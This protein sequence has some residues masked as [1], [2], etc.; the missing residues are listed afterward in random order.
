MS[1]KDSFTKRRLKQLVKEQLEQMD[2]RAIVQE[3]LLANA[4]EDDRQEQAQ[5]LRLAALKAR[6]RS[7][8]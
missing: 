8:R 5:Q 6:Q 2:I 4:A 3:C 7:N 1:S